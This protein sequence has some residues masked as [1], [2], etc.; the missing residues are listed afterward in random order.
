M[1]LKDKGLVLC[2]GPRSGLGAC[3]LS[4]SLADAVGRFGLSAC[5]ISP[6]RQR[7]RGGLFMAQ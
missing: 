6:P 5:S 2:S 1:L 7:Y 3:P 4:R